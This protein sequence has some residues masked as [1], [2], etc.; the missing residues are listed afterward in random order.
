MQEWIAWLELILRYLAQNITKNTI[1]G[2]NDNK[3]V[4]TG[5]VIQKR[6]RSGYKRVQTVTRD[7]IFKRGMFSW[8]SRYWDDDDGSMNFVDDGMGEDWSD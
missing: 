4:E 5:D 8:E 7:Q 6:F 2:V 3:L 1:V